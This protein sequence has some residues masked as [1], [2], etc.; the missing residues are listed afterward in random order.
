MRAQPM[1][2]LAR[3]SVMGWPLFYSAQPLSRR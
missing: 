3:L 1:P 2:I